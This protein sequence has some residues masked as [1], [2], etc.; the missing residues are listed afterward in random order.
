[1]NVVEKMF[2]KN[3]VEK[4]FLDLTAKIIDR[5]IFTDLHI[6]ATDRHQSSISITH[7]Y[8]LTILNGRQF[9]AMLFQLVGYVYLKMTLLDTGMKLNLG[10]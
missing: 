5:K 2:R 1:M 4:T 7:R 6:K 8:T 3:V 10:F 9:I